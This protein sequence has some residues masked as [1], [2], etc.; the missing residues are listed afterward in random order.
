MNYLK[1][2]LISFVIRC[3]GAT[4]QSIKIGSYHRGTMPEFLGG[5]RPRTKWCILWC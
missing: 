5:L 1:G 3:H 4:V 2:I